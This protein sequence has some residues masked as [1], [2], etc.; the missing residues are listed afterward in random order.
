MQDGNVPTPPSDY[1]VHTLDVY[2]LC[3]PS[4]GGEHSSASESF[5]L[6][7]SREQRVITM[8]MEIRAGLLLKG[9]NSEGDR[10]REFLVFD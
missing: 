10:Y 5:V 4:G 8:E 1:Y 3:F 6:E 7:M 2:F 9:M